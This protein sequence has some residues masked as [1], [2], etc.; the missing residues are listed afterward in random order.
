MSELVWDE[1]MSVGIDA[2]DDDHKQIIAILAKLSVTHR[3]SISN[4]MIEDIFCELESYVTLHFSREER[5]LEK[6][7]YQDLVNHKASHQ[8]FIEKLPS[9]KQQW[10]S[11]GNGACGEKI[12]S[13]L[14]N[15]LVDHIFK[16]DFDY[17][18]TLQ[19]SSNPEVQRLNYAGSNASYN[20]ENNSLL[21]KFSHLISHKIKLSKRIFM[22]AFIPVMGVLLLSLVVIQDNYQRYKNMSL[23]LNLNN[24]IIEVENVNHSLQIERGLSS[25]LVNSNYQ[26][27]T[28]DL[29]KQR[30]ITDQANDKFLVLMEKEIDPVVKNNIQSYFELVRRDIKEL[31][32]NRQH[33]D[34][35][36]DSFLSIHQSYTS[37]IEQLLSISENLTNV[38]DR[39]SVV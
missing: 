17:I 1:G 13:F 5:L 2:I 24:V 21:A 31:F 10:L 32:V 22:I 28:N 33:V 3:Q 14:N 16:E 29:L 18:E 39:K 27:F 9:L 12:T 25:G 4:K 30:L 19:N 20:S 35:K 36:S 11:E 8:R 38:E 15:W 37:L 7:D 23:L 34:N 6:A 26:Y